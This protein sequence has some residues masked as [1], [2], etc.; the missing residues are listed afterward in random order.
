M[1]LF[2]FVLIVQNVMGIALN[3]WCFGFCDGILYFIFSNLFFLQTKTSRNCEQ[4]EKNAKKTSAHAV[5]LSMV[6]LLLSVL[7]KD[8]EEDESVVQRALE[9]CTLLGQQTMEISSHAP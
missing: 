5:F 6:Y 3:L 7:R 8:G 4:T 2:F 1:A 9:A